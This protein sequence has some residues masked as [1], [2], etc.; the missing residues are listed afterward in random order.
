MRGSLYLLIAL[1]TAII[2]TSAAAQSWVLP[3]QLND[4]NT[5][6]SFEVD[7][8]WHL[9]E[10]TTS[11][12][13][14][15]VRQRDPTDPLSIEVDLVVP[16]ASFDT[17]WDARD[18]KLAFVMAADR[19]AQVRFRSS[20]LTANCHP[21]TI[22]RD[23]RCS[24]SLEGTLTMRDVTLPVSLPVEIMRSGSKDTISGKLTLEWADYHV[25][26]PSILIAKLDSAVTIAYS[27]E[28][29]LR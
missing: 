17:D 2:S 12:I 29:P 16:V 21:L 7:S 26:D 6:V 27:T 13:S 15:F 3:A 19:F 10:G 18:E 20:K 24:G 25:E 28:I 9:V 5:T 1:R 22:K 11:K 8:T 14:G 23:G 4:S